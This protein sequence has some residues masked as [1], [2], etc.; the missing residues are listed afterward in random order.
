[1]AASQYPPG[2]DPQK[3][4]IEIVDY[5]PAW[6]ELFRK[7]EEA[8]RAQLAPLGGF[9]MEHYGSTSVR[10]L[11]AKPIIDIM[12][13][14]VSRKDWPPLVKPIE[15]LGYVFNDHDA[16]PDQLFFVKGMPPFGKKRTHHIH[17]YEWNG[18]RWK[19]ELSF[20]DYLRGHPEESQK[21]EALKRSLAAQFAT[22]REAYT[23]AKGGFIQEVMRK[24]GP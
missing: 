9:F 5:D 21:Y 16:D 8:L 12:I 23:E 20:R 1:M 15:G 19:T 6:P 4:R 3:D 24:I 17:V 14:T 10:G 13:G 18:P 2:Y 22:N 11:A 7:E